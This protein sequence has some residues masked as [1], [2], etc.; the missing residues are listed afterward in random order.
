MFFP[1][2]PNEIPDLIITNLHPTAAIALSQ[3]NRY[4][5]ST[6]SLHRLDPDTV[7]IFLKDLEN[8]PANNIFSGR[9]KLTFACCKCLCRQP[10]RTFQDPEIR[11]YDRRQCLEC[12]LQDGRVTPGGICSSY[13]HDPSIIC[14]KCLKAR[15]EFCRGCDACAPCL[16]K[17]GVEFCRDCGWCYAC[18]GLKS[19]EGESRNKTWEPFFVRETCKH[20]V[21]EYGKALDME[22]ESEENQN[23]DVYEEGQD[24][25]EDE[26]EES[27]ASRD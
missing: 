19:L 22:R 1:H 16:E 25:H 3:T 4:Y 5:H 17:K 13:F 15:G 27:N 14:V 8:R 21:P 10:A 23:E 6:V 24:M 12:D 20:H 7:R 2:L 26:Y 11:S 9:S 18:E